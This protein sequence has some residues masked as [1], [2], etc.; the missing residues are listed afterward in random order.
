[1]QIDPKSA[2]IYIRANHYSKGCHNGP[3]PCFGLFDAD[4][5]L[6]GVL[7][8]AV[9]CSENVRRVVFGIGQEHMTIEL[10]RLHIQDVT[11]KNAESWFIARCM[12][13][14]KKIKP[15]IRVVVSYS[16][17]TQGHDGTIYAASNFILTGKELRENYGYHYLDENGRIRHTRQNGVNIKPNE[18]KARG[19]QVIYRSGKRRWHFPLGDSLSDNRRIRRRLLEIAKENNCV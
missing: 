1:M 14:L 4:Y 17:G 9:S 13:M 6:I 12:R 11:P 10:H 18:A 5:E 19:W 2:K 3:S 7:M 15:E 8:F 16:D